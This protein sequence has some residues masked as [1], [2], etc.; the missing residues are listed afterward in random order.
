MDA[1]DYWKIYTLNKEQPKSTSAFNKPEFPGLHAQIV[2]YVEDPVPPTPI[3]D[4]S[5]KHWPITKEEM[6]L[7]RGQ[8]LIEELPTSAVA[9]HHGFFSTSEESEVSDEF[10][11][12][13]DCCMFKLIVQPGV[14]YLPIW[15]VA[16]GFGDGPDGLKEVLIEAGLPYEIVKTEKMKHVDESLPPVTVYNVIYGKPPT[17]PP[18]ATKPIFAP[19]GFPTLEMQNYILQGLGQSMGGSWFQYAGEGKFIISNR[20]GKQLVL[21]MTRTSLD[22]HKST[23]VERIVRN[24]LREYAAP[25]GGSRKN[26][27]RRKTQRRKTQR[28]K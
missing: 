24:I 12:E 11:W 8:P 19:D 26:K 9:H 18:K 14:R 1:A 4:A 27:Q 16:S 21:T 22:F 2:S 15:S 5:M 6:T 28:R 25:V 17:T 7:W 13:N 3:L 23:S 10:T 20:N